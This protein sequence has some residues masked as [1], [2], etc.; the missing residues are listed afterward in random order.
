MGWSVCGKFLGLGRQE[1]DLFLWLGTQEG[2]LFWLVC[3]R[4]GRRE[5]CVWVWLVAFDSNL[6]R[7]VSCG[8]RLYLICCC[9]VLKSEGHIK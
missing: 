5:T 2:D 1:G 8:H 3:R 7:E 9:G 6:R 4:E